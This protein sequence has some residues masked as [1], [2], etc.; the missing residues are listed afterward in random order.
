MELVL[1]LQQHQFKQQLWQKVCYYIS[2]YYSYK[3]SFDNYNILAPDAAPIN[4]TATAIDS[5][6]I[7]VSWEP[8][9]PINQNG[10]ISCYNITFFGFPFDT[11]QQYYIN[12]IMSSYPDNTS[13]TRILIGLQEYNNYTI[14][15]SAVNTVGKGPVSQG[16]TVLTGIGGKLFLQQIVLTN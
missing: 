8:P 4:I 13:Y 2:Q 15:I 11:A 6:R 1:D 7:Q 10:E 9:P 14:S 12:Y 16:I 5:T 3:H